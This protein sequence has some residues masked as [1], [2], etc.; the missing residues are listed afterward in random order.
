MIK[1]M[2]NT[3]YKEKETKK[4]LCKFINESDRLS[5]GS[6]CKEFE[7]EFSTWQ[8]RKY[9][10]LFN[11]GSSAN[12]ALMQSL[13]NLGYLNHGDNVGFSGL[14]WATNVMPIIQMG[15]NP[16]PIDISLKN[17]NVNLN[18]L[19]NN[20]EEL[21]AIF[22]T[23]LLGFCGDIDKIKKYC[24][25]NGIILVE[26]NCESLG[27]TYKN[28]NL[29]NFGLASTFSFFVGHHLSTIEGG[30]VCTDN[31]NL[32]NMLLMVRAHGWGRNLDKSSKKMLVQS[33]NLDKFYS[34]YTFYT[35]GYNLRPTEITGFLGIEQLKY[36]ERI[37]K[38]R[39]KI[40]KLY[41]RFSN[42]NKDILNLDF[43]HMDFVSNFAYPLIFKDKETFEK[44]KDEFSGKVEIRPIVGGSICK[45]PFYNFEGNCP[46]ADKIHEWGFYIPNNPELTKEELKEICN[47]IKGD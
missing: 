33:N 36:V 42:R 25:E 18:N 14:T 6:K 3:F 16:I 7:G 10:V 27:S 47:L 35:S 45:Q 4:R 28:E 5:M 15:F 23:N 12:L 21:K 17:L 37:C 24:N 30:I 32:Y 22:L 26:D 34:P 44:Y 40:F 43:S 20:D 31:K 13:V 39:N 38:T 8:G 2:K 29:G 19:R 46:N 1:L 11:S 41:Q 9:S